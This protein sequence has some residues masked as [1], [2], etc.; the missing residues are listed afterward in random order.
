MAISKLSP[1]FYRKYPL[2]AALILVTTIAG[3]FT[4]S[5]VEA[6]TSSGNDCREQHKVDVALIAHKDSV[7]TSLND[8]VF[9]LQE[10]LLI[11]NGII[12][13]IPEKLDSI[14]K[15]HR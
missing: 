10:Q 15:K 2:V 6:S 1:E 5:F 4:R 8:R 3:Y 7:I 14:N 12:D 9:D 11:T 13:R